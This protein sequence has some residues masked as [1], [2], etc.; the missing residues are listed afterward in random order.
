MSPYKVSFSD[1]GTPCA[2]LDIL[3]KNNNV[4]SQEVE[5]VLRAEIEK[6]KDRT[7]R[8]IRA[9]AFLEGVDYELHPFGLPLPDGST[10][11]TYY[12]EAGKAMTGGE[13]SGGHD[14]LT[15][16]TED[17][18]YRTDTVQSFGF[19]GYSEWLDV[20]IV[21]KRIEFSDPDEFLGFLYG[22]VVEL[23]DLVKDLSLNIL[24]GDPK[25]PMSWR[26]ICDIDGTRF[27]FKYDAKTRSV[28][29]GKKIVARI[30]TSGSDSKPAKSQKPPTKGKRKKK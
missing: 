25:N 23:S 8:P 15:S 2:L 27:D 10:S 1:G 12:H 16:E 5:Q 17:Y 20:K 18:F 24:A 22:I 4:T 6:H 14:D 11:I 28:R 13:A 19:D 9:E 30:P 21:F 26:H 3:F 29:S 7:K